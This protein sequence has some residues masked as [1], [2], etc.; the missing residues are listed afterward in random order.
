MTNPKTAKE[1][2]KNAPHCD[3]YDCNAYFKGLCLALSDNRFKDDDH[4]PFF[5]TKEQNEKECEEC[6]RRLQAIRGNVKNEKE[7]E[8]C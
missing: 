2:Q 5:K 3:Q 7:N 8:T 4:C 1:V 6:Q